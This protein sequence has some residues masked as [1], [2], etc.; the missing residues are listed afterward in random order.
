MTEKPQP[1][2]PVKRRRFGLFRN[3]PAPAPAAVGVA[4]APTPAPAAPAPAVPAAPVPKQRGKLPT[5][6][7][8]GAPPDPWTAFAST[9]ERG[10]GRIRRGSRWLGRNLVHEYALAIYASCLVAVAMTWPALRYPLYTLPQDL[11]DPSR[12]AWQVSWA[13]HILSTNPVKLWQSNAY[14]P[15]PFNFAFGDSLV[16]YAFAGMIGTGPAAAILRYNVLF[17]LAHALLMFGAYVLVRQLGARPTGAAVAAVAFAYAP[18]RL[19]QEGHLDIVSAGGIPLALALLARAH[20]YSLRWGLRPERR[21]AGWAAAGWL[22][23]CWQLMLGFSLGVP[24]A[25]VLGLLL[26]VI[27]CAAVYRHVR[28][29][30]A[31]RAARRAVRSEPAAAPITEKPVAESEVAK[32]ARMDAVA[33]T[34]AVEPKGRRRWLLFGA[35]QPVTEKARKRAAARAPRPRPA[36]PKKPS[37]AWWL[38]VVNA[39]GAQTFV[40]VGSVLALPYVRAL[41]TGSRIEEITFFSPPLRSLLIGPAESRIWGAAHAT[42]RDSL[43]WAGEMTLL[44]GFALY[45]LALAG[46]VLSVW[47]LRHRLMLVAGLAVAVI[48]TLGTTFFGGRWTYLP[49]FGHFP[50]SFD[51]RV[52]GRLMLW[53]TLLLAILAAGAVDALVRR[54]EQLAAQRTPPWPGP[55]LRLAT[56]TPLVLVLVEG[57]NLTAHP[58]V[59]AQPASMRTVAGPMLVLPTA[60][61]SDQ[62]VQ[63]WTTSKF[64][65]IANG[66]GTFAAQQQTE[67][68]ARVANFPDA[69]SSDYLISMGVTKVLLLRDM[70]AGTPWEVAADRPVDSLG[71]RREDLEDAV[72]FYLN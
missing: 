59:P 57:W 69:A 20:G 30:L 29:L 54:T 12:Q 45:A 70:V 37:T 36:P 48:L 33:G 61:L 66:G 60:D 67:L 15:E 63:L 47:R 42:P 53:V 44:P 27:F 4:T 6:R 25:Y 24:F 10:P 28:R 56:L 13:G 1:P 72:V 9:P 18:W 40:A 38:F 11:G 58:V 17:V 19:A 65:Q 43:G 55:W 62:T 3:R 41:D 39:L 52:P 22:V 26:I 32:A 8:A 21:H 46:L 64:Q 31:D 14:Y 16:G 50:A 35:R 34:P 68:R 7:P 51:Q 5:E 2:A 23:A 49:L 71:I